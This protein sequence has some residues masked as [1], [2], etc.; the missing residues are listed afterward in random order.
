MAA[1]TVVN[2]GTATADGTE[3]TLHSTSTGAH[4][5]ATVDLTN[6][7]SGDVVEIRVYKKVLTGSTLKQVDIYTFSGTQTSPNFF[8]PFV[9]SP[10][11]YK[12]TLKQTSGAN[13]NFEW[14][15]ETP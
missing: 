10:F 1:P 4:Y 6:L 5:S 15:V 13:R 2:S 14:S 7:A 3:Q 9:S 8:I 11:G 12:L